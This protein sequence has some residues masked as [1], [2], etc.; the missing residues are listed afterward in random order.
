MIMV[1]VY[2]LIVYLTSMKILST[3]YVKNAKITV[4]NVLVKN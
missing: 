2:M 4:K 1:N 3:K